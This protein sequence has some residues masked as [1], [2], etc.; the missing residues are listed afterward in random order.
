MARSS[1]QRTL[2]QNFLLGGKD[3]LADAASTKGINTLA[4]LHA[5]TPAV[6]LPVVF[7]LSSIA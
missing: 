5:P 7:A 3:E 1:A 2:P 4:I 6:A